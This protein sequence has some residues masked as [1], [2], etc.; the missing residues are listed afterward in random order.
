MFFTSDISK[1]EVEGE[2]QNSPRSDTENE[3]LKE[4][5]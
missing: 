2:P 4:K 5:V 3:K 1:I